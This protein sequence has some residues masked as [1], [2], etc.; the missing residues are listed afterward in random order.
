MLTN[1]VNTPGHEPKIQTFFADLLQ[2]CKEEKFVDNFITIEL[3]ALEITEIFT[4][5]ELCHIRDL[6]KQKKM[7][8]GLKKVMEMEDLFYH[9]VATANNGK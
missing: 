8:S 4:N 1:L 9:A 5:E 6:K 2:Y 7:S 3:E